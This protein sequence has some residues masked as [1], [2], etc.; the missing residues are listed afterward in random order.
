MVSAA[1]LAG[2]ALQMAQNPSPMS[3][4]TRA[5]A[6]LN[7]HPPTG[8]RSGRTLHIGK[9]G[10]KDPVIIHFHGS[11]WLPEQATASVW[12]HATVAGIHIGAGSGVY[13]AAFSSPAAFQSLLD[14]AGAAGRPVILTAWSAGYG[15]IRAILGHSYDRID[16]IILMDALHSGYRNKE[17]D[18]EGL[19]VF[20]R[21]AT[22]AAQGRKSL[23]LTHS[24]VYPGTFASTTESAS[25]LL[26]QLHLP[27]RAVLRWGPGGMQQLSEVRRGRL[28]FLGFAGNSA[29]DHVDHLHGMATWLR[30]LRKL[31]W[32]KR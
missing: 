22:D 7:Q 23:L 6:R 31:G 25:W 26:G 15:A 5:H 13:T 14:E 9:P 29:P 1:L 28:I 27:R 21:F 16:G 20:L 18:P 19:D 12:R 30:T 17:T 11:P 8:L 24:E 32:T 2:L 10:P 3:E 4:D